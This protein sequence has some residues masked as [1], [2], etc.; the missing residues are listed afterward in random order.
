MV[1]M[2]M[3]VMMVVIVVGMLLLGLTDRGYVIFLEKCY[4]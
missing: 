3:M 2:V 4:F 1:M